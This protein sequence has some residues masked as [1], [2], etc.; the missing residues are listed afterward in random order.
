MRSADTEMLYEFEESLWRTE[1]RFDRAYME[2]LLH[3]EFFEFGRSGRVYTRAQTLD[4]T[5]VVIDAELPLR[6]FAVHPVD[7]RAVLVTYLS[8]VQYEDLEVGNRSS[9]WVR[10]GDSWQLRFHQGTAVID[11]EA[12]TER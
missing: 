12:D 5:R 7:N 2:R 6:G 1:T 9:L 8:I 3:P 11:Q 10:N 4:A